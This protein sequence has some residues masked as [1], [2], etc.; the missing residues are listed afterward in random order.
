MEMNPAFWGLLKLAVILF[1]IRWG[2]YFIY[3]ILNTFRELR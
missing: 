2:V 1:G 3:R